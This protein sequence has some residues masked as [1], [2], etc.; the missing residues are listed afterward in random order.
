[1]NKLFRN[2]ITVVATSVIAS[3][4]FASTLTVSASSYRAKNV[5][6]AVQRPLQY[7]DKKQLVLANQD[8]KKRAVDA[9]IQLSYSEKPT[10]KRNAKLEFNPVG[11]HNY[12][13]KYQKSN[14]SISK[15]WLFNRGHLVGYQFSGLNDEARNL[16]TE[17]AYLNT[18]ALKSMNSGNKKSMLYYESHLASWLKSHKTY[19]L[20]YQVTPLYNAQELLPRQIRL[21]YVG[22]SKGGKEVAIHF[23][24]SREEK[25]TDGATVVYLNNDSPNAIINYTD[26]T[27]KNTLNKKKTIAAAE[28]AS[29]SSSES[30]S[31]Y[32]EYSESSSRSAES[33]SQSRASSQ[34]VSESKAIADSQSSEAKSQALAQSQAAEEQSKAASQSSVESSVVTTDNNIN[35]TDHYKWAIQDGFNWDNRKGHSTRIAPG[36]PLPAGYHWQV[37]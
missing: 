17:T 31:A 23:N 30:S 27:A 37:Q 11:W 7:Q 22:Y 2:V 25:G 13:F 26:G 16:V 34:A 6:G 36:Q 3:S 33:E 8:N 14:G 32:K 19:R 10:T 29:R 5:S 20:D 28:S 21:A 35:S 15:S 18:G 9:H 24:S 12:R 1:M 4:T